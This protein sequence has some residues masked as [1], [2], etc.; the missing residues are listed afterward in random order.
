MRSHELAAANEWILIRLPALLAALMVAGLV[1]LAMRAIAAPRGVQ[2]AAWITGAIAALGLVVFDAGPAATL[3]V[4]PYG[5]FAIVV[6]VLA[7]RRIPRTPSEISIATGMLFVPAAATWLVSARA[8]YELLGYAPFWVLLTSAHFHVAGMSLLIVLGCVARERRIAGVV[9]LACV[10][11]VPLTAAGIYGPR[12]LEVGAA[13]FMATS[14][15]AAGLV[16]VTTPRLRI[17][18]AILLVSMPLA[19]MFALRDHGTAPSFFGFEPLGSMLASHGVLNV[20]AAFVAL[21][22]LSRSRLARTRA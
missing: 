4:V 1:P 22:S 14:A 13:V 10:L 12:W 6:G 16:L 21:G 18:G 5:A 11:A 15:F 9:A 2:H 8:G 17:A 20:I 19:G 7:V 3:T